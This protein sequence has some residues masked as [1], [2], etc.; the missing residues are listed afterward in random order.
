MEYVKDCDFVKNLDTSNDES[1]CQFISWY[2]Y[3]QDTKSLR[4]FFPKYK[5]KS[6][7]LFMLQLMDDLGKKYWSYNI[8]SD[9]YDQIQRQALSEKETT[10][11]RDYFLKKIEEL[12]RS[13]WEDD[14]QWFL[15]SLYRKDLLKF[16]DFE[17]EKGKITYILQTIE[18]PTKKRNESNARIFY[19]NRW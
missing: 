12:R 9:F 8:Y 16:L 19:S 11:K 5:E 18:K 3:V 7:N 10:E 14:Y 4:E 6:D 17:K 15:Y 2:L 13:Y 1:V